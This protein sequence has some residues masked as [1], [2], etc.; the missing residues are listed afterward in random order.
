MAGFLFAICRYDLYDH[1]FY[2]VLSA[3]L[4]GAYYVGNLLSGWMFAYRYLLTSRTLAQQVNPEKEEPE[5]EQDSIKDTLL[6]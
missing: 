1:W 6:E 2:A 3:I 4:L 5:L